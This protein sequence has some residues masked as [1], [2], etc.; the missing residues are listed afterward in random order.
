MSQNIY[1]KIEKM[2]FQR[3]VEWTE[4]RKRE[5]SRSGA[6]HHLLDF[7]VAHESPTTNLLSSDWIT[8]S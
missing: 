5:A 1:K 8:I 4:Y 6:A 7:G 2:G 3:A